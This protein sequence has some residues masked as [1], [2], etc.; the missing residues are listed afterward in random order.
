[1]SNSEHELSITRFIDAS[2]ETVYRVY[3]ERTAEWWAPKPWKSRVIAQELRPG[4]RSSI[5]M[6]GPNGEQHP[7][8]G[9]Y[10]E[11]VPNQRIVFTNAFTAGWQPKP[12]MQSD[13]DFLM[14]AIVEFEPE[15]SGTRYTARVRH[16]NEEAQKAHEAMGFEE[17]WGICAAQLAELAEAEAHATVAA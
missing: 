15:G 9:V 13:C 5:E 17:G 2:P 1:M 16:W 7:G 8:E 4:G 14:V 11:V 10:L 3:T 6:E 12:G